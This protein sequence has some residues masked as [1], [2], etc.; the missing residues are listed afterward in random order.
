[1]P[2]KVATPLTP[3]KLKVGASAN[4]VFCMKHQAKTHT[5]L[6]NTPTAA[7]KVSPVEKGKVVMVQKTEL[8][9]PPGQFQVDVPEF[10]PSPHVH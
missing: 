2:T 7:H 3:S 5:S 6:P 9:P 1:M 4:K 8:P 10:V